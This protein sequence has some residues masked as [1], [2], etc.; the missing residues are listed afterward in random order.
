MLKTKENTFLWTLHGTTVGSCAGGAAGSWLA[1]KQ[2][3]WT[4]FISVPTEC[5]TV[6]ILMPVY[7]VNVPLFWSA[8]CIGIG[9][10]AFADYEIGERIDR[11]KTSALTE[12]NEKTTWRTGC[13]IASAIP[14]AMLGFYTFAV[15]VISHFGKTD[16]PNEM[17]NNLETEIPALL[18][19]VGLTIE[20]IHLS[21]QIG[22]TIDQRKA[23]NAT[24]KN[25]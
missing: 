15:L 14:V 8:A 6:T 22:R 1:I 20:V 4:E 23:Y 24:K 18:V 10:G 21:Y 16:V 19:G 2:S 11:N 13:A 12:I 7:D 5:G 25:K 17:R 9:T 3:G